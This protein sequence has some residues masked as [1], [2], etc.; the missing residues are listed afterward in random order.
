MTADSTASWCHSSGLGWV[1]LL[2]GHTW[3]IV[4]CPAAWCQ[5]PCVM[6]RRDS[7]LNA[8]C[9][10]CNS[11]LLLS[12]LSNT[13]ICFVIHAC[14]PYTYGLV[15][16]NQFFIKL[17]DSRENSTPKIKNIRNTKIPFAIRV[18]H[19]KGCLHKILVSSNVSVQFASLK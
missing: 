2:D 13:A 19:V 9:R 8:H 12:G 14:W 17:A 7:P 1:V 10:Q 15:S 18:T 11:E 6:V 3:Q 16:V 5:I 4:K